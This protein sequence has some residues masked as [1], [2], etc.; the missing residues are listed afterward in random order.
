MWFGVDPFVLVR[1]SLGQPR[2]FS[3]LLLYVCSGGGD[4]GL[5]AFI[6]AP[7]CAGQQ[8]VRPPRPH[9]AGVCFGGVFIP[10]LHIHIRYHFFDF[11]CFVSVRDRFQPSSSLE[12]SNTGYMQASVLPFRTNNYVLSE[13]IDWG[14]VPHCPMFRLVDPASNRISLDNLQPLH[15]VVIPEKL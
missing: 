9:C 4:T 12:I 15:K 2:S 6:G 5:I 11:D 10:S 1:S 3:A 7:C 13:L 14:R 8:T